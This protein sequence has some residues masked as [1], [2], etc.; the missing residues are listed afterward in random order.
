MNIEEIGQLKVGEVL[1]NQQLCDLFG[2]SPQ[3]GMRKSN[4]TNTLLLISNHINSIYDDRWENDILHYTGM[5]TTGDQSLDFA[6]N[7]TLANSQTNNVKVHLFEVFRDKQYTYAGQ[8]TLVAK[9]YSEYQPDQA[10]QSRLVY[11]FP[12]QLK[13]G[14]HFVVEEDRQH[15]YQIKEKRA[16]KLS[17]AELARRAYQSKR[18]T[19]VTKSTATIYERN[20]WVTEHAKRLANGICQLCITPAPFSTPKGVPYLETHHIHWLSRGGDDTPHNTIALCPNCHKKMHILDLQTDVNFLFQRL[21]TLLTEGD[22]SAE[23]QP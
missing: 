14:A 10:G 2:C 6:Q 12:L 8:V 1:D 7:K 11:V 20:V 19:S 23:G 5:G 22:Q 13:S 18:K 15:V 4:S 16:K 9:P 3:G 21:N 17:D